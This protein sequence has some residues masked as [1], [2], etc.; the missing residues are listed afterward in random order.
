MIKVGITGNIASGKSTF[1]TFFNKK[2][3]FIFNA[4]KE[5]KKHL[6]KHSV[7]QKKLVNSFGKKILIGKDLD[8]K[9]LAEISFENKMNQKILN[10]IIWPEILILIERAYKEAQKQKCNYFIVDAALLFEANY[11]NFFDYIILIMASKEN[12]L[13]RAIKRKNI[14][15][16][17]INKRMKLQMPDKEKKYLSHFIIKNDSDIAHLEKQFETIFKKLI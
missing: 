16:A 4:D 1:T 8:F 3:T 13:K 12:R 14:D 5:A 2:N 15:V 11:Q 6:K 9:K 10:G 7:L 17:Q